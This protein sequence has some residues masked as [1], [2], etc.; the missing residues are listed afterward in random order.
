LVYD[1]SRGP[2]G[3]RRWELSD[4][5]TV[6]V[7]DCDQKTRGLVAEQV[8]R[9]GLACRQA[10]TGEAALAGLEENE[11]AL[12][13]IEVEL[14]GLNGLGLLQALHERFEGLPVILV[15]FK[16]ADPV[17][18]AAGLMLGADDYLVKPL[19]P[20]ELAAR[21]RRSLRRSGTPVG[22][23]RGNGRSSR[24]PRLSPREREI[25]TLLAEGKTQKQIAAVLTL[26]PK[27]V[28]TH[29]QNLLRK[30]GV[31]SRAQAVVAAYRDGFVSA[32]SLL[33]ALLTSTPS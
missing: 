20:T 1:R 6:L 33:M 9:L 10:D 23:D 32:G 29:I 28:A 3:P 25:L 16:H 18:R 13:V 14:P 26:S 11:L 27:T 8:R 2:E 19:D 7:V 17:E 22:N 21:M 24:V 30:L 12:A 15:S 31:H 4:C 5:G